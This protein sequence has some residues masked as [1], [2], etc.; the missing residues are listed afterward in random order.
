MNISAFIMAMICL[1]TLFPLKTVNGDEGGYKYLWGGFS[2][3]LIGRSPAQMQNAGRAALDIDGI[4]IPPGGVFSFNKLVGGRDRE[5][6]YTRAP[7]IDGSGYLQDIP[8]GGICQLA[9]TIYNAALYAGLEIVERHPHSRAVSYVPPGRDATIATWRKDLKLRNPHRLPF[10][11]RISMKD[12][13]ITAGFWSIEDKQFKIEIVTERIPLEP[14][15]AAAESAG[16]G[17][18]GGQAGGTGFS[19]ITRRFVREGDQVREQAASQDFYP[20]PTRVL[21]GDRP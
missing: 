8:G 11:L 21:K 12:G 7:M 3:S 10:V 9:T 17:C 14:S 20:P 13:R 16:S 6:G 18:R 2:T 5:K 1:F 15:T 4:I 19:V